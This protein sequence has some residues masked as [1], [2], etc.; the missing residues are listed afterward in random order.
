MRVIY[1]IAMCVL[2]AFGSAAA[3]KQNVSGNV[4]SKKF[5]EDLDVSGINLNR[6]GDKAILTFEDQFWGVSVA[7]GKTLWTK[8]LDDDYDKKWDLVNWVDDSVVTVPSI[9]ALEWI[10]GNTGQ[11]LAS[12]PFPGDGIDDLRTEASKAG[13]T[14]YV[15]VERF[16]SL[17][18]VPFSDTYQVID[19]YKRKLIYQSSEE[20]ADLRYHIWGSTLLIGGKMDSVSMFDMDKGTLLYKQDMSDHKFDPELYQS[21]IRYKDLAVIILEEE[22]ILVNVATGKQIALLELDIQDHLT[23]EPLILNGT[24]HLLLQ[25]DED[26]ALLNVADGKMLWKK[27]ATEEGFGHA[28][29][30][31]PYESTDVLITTSNEDDDIHVRRIN[32]KD[33]KVEWST[34]LVRCEKSFDPGHFN[35]TSALT[36]ALTGQYPFNSTN[37]YVR[38]YTLDSLARQTFYSQLGI[39]SIGPYTD[40]DFMA[41]Q[42]VNCIHETAW[43][44]GVARYIG[45]INGKIMAVTQ[46]L[47]SKAWDGKIS[48]EEADGEAIFSID[49]S[50]GKIVTVSPTAF[51]RNTEGTQKYNVYRYFMPIKNAFGTSIM[52]EQTMIYIRNSG[53]VDSLRFDTNDEGLFSMG[54][55]LDYRVVYHEDLDDHFST[56]KISFSADG[57][58]RQLVCH[59]DESKHLSMFSD[60]LLTTVTLRYE[61]GNLYAYDLL[62]D[63]PKQWPKPLWTLNEDALEDLGVGSFE[64]TATVNDVLGIHPYEDHVLIMGTDGVA[65]VGAKDGCKKVLEWEGWKPNQSFRR[66]LRLFEPMKGGFLFDFGPSAG[67]IKLNGKCDPTM[68]AYTD[69]NA[70]DLKIV[71]SALTSTILTVDTSEN[72]LDIYKLNK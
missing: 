62:S 55:G 47:V 24:L 70:N 53:A 51:T 13:V 10:N 40:E 9:K 11:V 43:G 71:F 49:P 18:I 56:W 2:C 39:D 30:A 1:A 59:A 20:L 14:D 68:L 4:L 32:G 26:L 25:T 45:T 17:L 22:V 7:D 54:N 72:R 12:V 69:A 66:G 64:A 50:T 38:N 16:G 65:F 33:G 42:S 67:V 52:G 27:A 19:L 34:M 58:K 63:N 44:A 6:S 31:W 61:G 35:N 21:L 29:Q 3:Q 48:E 15:T 46:G 41:L 28:I 37:S 5:S 60:T 8:K 23:Y 36:K 57:M